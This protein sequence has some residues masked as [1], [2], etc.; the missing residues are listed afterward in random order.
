MK[1]HRDMSLDELLE[2]ER[3]LVFDRFDED[4]AWELGTLLVAEARERKLAIAIDVRRGARILFHA[5]RP[6]TAEENDRWI[7]RKS[8]SVQR[9]GHSS[10]YIGRRL[11]ALG[12]TIEQ[13][14]F[15]PAAD[16]AFHGG[17]VPISVK[18]VGMVGS[19]AVSGL[20]QEEDHAMVTGAIRRMLGIE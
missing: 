17:C 20:S 14:Y 18:G 10:Y 3:Q 11:A 7:D 5:A 19:V 4:T 1:A 9:F 13:K 12:M 8:R 16:Y 15:V 6:G 2:E